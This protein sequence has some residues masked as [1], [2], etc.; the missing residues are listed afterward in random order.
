MRLAIAINTGTFI[1]LPGASVSAL[2][3]QPQFRNLGKLVNNSRSATVTISNVQLV[4]AVTGTISLTSGV[5]SVNF[6]PQN[7]GPGFVEPNGATLKVAIGGTAPGTGFGQLQLSNTA[8]LAGNLFVTNVRGF[9]PPPGQK[10]KVITCGT[11]CSGTFQL[12]SGG[13][14]VVYHPQDVTLKA[15]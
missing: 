13:Y 10:F 3:G 4:N 1:A 9:T 6:S 7:G 12:Q 2:N 11:A 15:Q 14:S 8:V 5:L